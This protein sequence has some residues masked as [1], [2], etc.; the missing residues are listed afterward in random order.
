MN[1]PNEN[2][3][4]I[5]AMDLLENASLNRRAFA[6]GMWQVLIGLSYCVWDHSSKQQLSY[7]V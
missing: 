6:P 1:Q 3:A 7:G 2:A 5:K 4:H